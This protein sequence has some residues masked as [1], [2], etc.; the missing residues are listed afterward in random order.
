MR[1]GA[2]VENCPETVVDQGGPGWKGR[3][4]LAWLGG[5]RNVSELARQFDKNWETVKKAIVDKSRA[6]ADAIAGGD[7]SALAEYVAGLEWDLGE[8]LKVYAASASGS[9]QIGALKHATDLREKIAAAL[10][11]PTKREVREDEGPPI[12]WTVQF[13]DGGGSALEELQARLDAMSE[14]MHEAGLEDEPY[15]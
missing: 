10:G 6:V 5:E 1:A 15:E 9:N 11:V 3:C 13:G 7:I 14:R 4:W 2:D 12:A 8:V